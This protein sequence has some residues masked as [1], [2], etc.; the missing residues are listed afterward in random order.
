MRKTE[1]HS[2]NALERAYLEFVDCRDAVQAAESRPCVPSAAASALS[3]GPVKGKNKETKTITV[4]FNPAKLSFSAGG[5]MREQEEEEEG[6][7]TRTAHLEPEGNEGER[8]DIQNRDPRKKKKRNPPPG[9]PCSLSLSV[10]LVFDGNAPD[11][12]P[13][14]VGTRVEALLEAAENPFIRQVS[15][16][17]GTLYY[18]GRITDIDV[19]YVMFDSL[20]SP[21]RANVSL[22][23]ELTDTTV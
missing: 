13:G 16:N 20:G 11:S 4:Q 19:E 12:R 10:E 6:E 14:E 15:F 1:N 7:K 8:G 9:K 3:G 23:M 2:E 5:G 21:L 17:W 18:E 22:S